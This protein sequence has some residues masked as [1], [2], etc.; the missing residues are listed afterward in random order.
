MEPFNKNL[1]KITFFIIT[2]RHVMMLWKKE[3]ENFEFLQGVIF[4][5]KDSLKNNGSK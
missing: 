1:T 3:I 2:V 5:P 4:E